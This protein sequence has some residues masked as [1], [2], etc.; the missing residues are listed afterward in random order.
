M[1]SEG[2]DFRRYSVRRIE[3]VGGGTSGEESEARISF[4]KPWKGKKKVQVL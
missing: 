3:V 4:Q 1:G 2:Q